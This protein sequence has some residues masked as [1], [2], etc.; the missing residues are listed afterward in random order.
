MSERWAD[1]AALVAHF[2]SPHMAVFQAA[3]ADAEREDGS[4]TLYSAELVRP[5]IGG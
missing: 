5:L 4:V 3:M 2:A 1:E